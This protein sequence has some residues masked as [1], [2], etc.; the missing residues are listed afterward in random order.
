MPDEEDVDGVDARHRGRRGGE[1]RQ[2]PGAVKGSKLTPEST[3]TAG[4][5][6]GVA[7]KAPTAGGREVSRRYPSE[8]CRGASGYRLPQ[9]NL[10]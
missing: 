3:T 4:L 10:L 2:A 1:L 5:E 7:C 9:D 8:S 6:R